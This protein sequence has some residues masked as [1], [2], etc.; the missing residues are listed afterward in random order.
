MEQI[1]KEKKRLKRFFI[2]KIQNKLGIT[3]DNIHV[4]IKIN[5]NRDFSVPKREEPTF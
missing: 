5:T 4:Y 1:V 2:L 3:T